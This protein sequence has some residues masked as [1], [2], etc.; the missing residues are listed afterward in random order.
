MRNL[1]SQ[2]AA[3]QRKS[4]AMWQDQIQVHQEFTNLGHRNII[5]FIA[6]ISRG[7]ERYLML[8]WADGG[9]LRQ[10]WSCNPLL[11]P[12]LVKDITHQLHGLADGLREIHQKNYR[13]G[14]IKPDNILRMNVQTTR[15]GFSGLDIGT[16]KISGM[17]LATQVQTGS[18]P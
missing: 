5:S 4:D 17:S 15:P 13:H 18:T 11:S 10:F 2:D 12:T 7:P 9:N 14:N 3:Q 16:L 6:A 8:E 1:Y